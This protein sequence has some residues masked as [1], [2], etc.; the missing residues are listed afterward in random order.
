MPTCDFP[1]VAAF[2]P[3]EWNGRTFDADFIR[4]LAANYKRF[5]LD[6]RDPDTG[7]PWYVPYVSIQHDL[8][9]ALAGFQFGQLQNV[10]VEPSGIL[11]MDANGVP[12]EVGVWRNSG[13]LRDPSI[14][15]IEPKRDAAG[16][17]VSGFKDSR[18][19]WVDGPVLK[20]LT[21]IG[22][23]SP[24]VKG[25]APLPTAVFRQ[26]RPVAPSLAFRTCGG[27]VL[28]F[29]AAVMD[30]TAILA[31]LTAAGLD[32]SQVTDAVPDAFLQAVLDMI[33]K[34]NANPA[35]ATPP[36]PD[37]SAVQMADATGAAA[38][39]LGTGTGAAGGLGGGNG[40]TGTPS[41]VVLKF[42]QQFPGLITSLLGQVGT[43]AQQSAGNAAVVQRIAANDKGRAIDAT[44]HRMSSNF[45]LTDAQAKALRPGLMS[46][47]HVTTRKFSD[48]KAAGTALEEQLAVMEA[49]FP[50]LRPTAA[51]RVAPRPL[52]AAGG[53]DGMT[54][55]RRARIISGSNAG[56]E[57]ARKKRLNGTGNT[58]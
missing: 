14:E 6:E 36:G 30:R 2:K 44:F 27:T 20:C 56:K 22:N 43:L 32:V 39:L 4:Q 17:I 38:A 46:L 9:P 7:H 11:R 48:G 29:G 53:S 54:A 18:G 58:V 16:Q 21:L 45:Q 15:I 50:K 42:N 47:D 3:G 57:L 23:D 24:G 33:Q 1:G 19:E 40:V 41:Q 5:A 49:T 35:P 51:D 28:R 34:G 31:A 26:F 8:N 10:H 12:A 52:P 13:M 25:N 37:P 55:E